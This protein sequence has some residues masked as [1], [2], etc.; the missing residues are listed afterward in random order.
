MG[1]LRSFAWVA[2]A[3][4]VL[5]TACPAMTLDDI[6]ASGTKPEVLGTGYG[7]CE[8]PA[9][10]AEGNIYFSD[11]KNDSIHFYE[12]GKP[13]SVFVDDSTDANGMMFNGKGRVGRLRGRRVPRRGL[14]REDQRAAGPRQA[15]STASI[16]TSR[17]ICRS[18][19]R[20][21]STSPTPTTSTAARRR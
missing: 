4:T 12:P 2:V 20:T 5:A 17:T 6:I 13:V 16:S 19:K 18:T 21:A 14:R 1:S 9:A 10:D 7:F 15:R 8:G 3:T 11:G